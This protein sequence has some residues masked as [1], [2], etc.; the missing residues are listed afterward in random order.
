MANVLA[1]IG[2]YG[3]MHLSSKNYG[4]HR[5]YPNES[6]EYFHKIT[7]TI[8]K[9]ELT[10]LIGT[11]DFTFGRF[12]SLEYRLA[13]EKELQEQYSSLNGNRYE[14]RGNHDD[15][16]YGLTE[17]DYYVS[18]GFLKPSCNLNIGNLHITMVDYGKMEDTIPNIVDD[19]SSI[20][21]L[22]IHDYVKFS[23]TQLPN[24]GK[25]FDLD[26][27]TKWFGAD[28]IACGHIHK[29][30]EFDGN[31]VK[32]GMAHQAHVNYLGCMMRPAYRQ[33]MMDEK[34]KILILTI[35]DDGQMDVDTEYIDLWSIEKSFNLE[36]KQKESVKK[37]EKAARVDISD[38]VKQ[39][40]THDRNVG[41]PEEIIN[42]LVGVDDKYK[43]K[44][45]ELLKSALA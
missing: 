32:D 3:D 25:P 10:H 45:I 31:I 30:M 24:F 29:D 20:N 19:M 39:L 37:E 21:L 33:G 27:Y 40:D 7:E 4:A 13:V 17:R 1:R 38:I 42:G 22:I 12:H 6:L 16:T 15:A 34:G 8:Q 41:S 11:G 5:D 9:R 44:A 14:L 23:T 28:Y 43:N 18:K 26:N 2:I 35:F 36:E